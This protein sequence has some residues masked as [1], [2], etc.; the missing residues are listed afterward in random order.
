MRK[1][2]RNHKLRS[3][4]RQAIE[5]GCADLVIWYDGYWKYDPCYEVQGRRESRKLIPIHKSYREDR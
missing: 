3:E 2:A 5:S 1:R 4:W